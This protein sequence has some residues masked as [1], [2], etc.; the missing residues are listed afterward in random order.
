[1]GRRMGVRH[2]PQLC[3]A[4]YRLV[5]HRFG[6]GRGGAEVSFRAATVKGLA[7]TGTRGGL[8][9][10]AWTSCPDKLLGQATWPS[11]IRRGGWATIA[12][13]ANQKPKKC[14][15]TREQTTQLRPR[16]ARTGAAAL[17]CARGRRDRADAAADAGG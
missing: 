6:R 16:R 2:L 10:A 7:G 13:G 14:E 9:S 17:D 11:L 8:S 3:L 12:F 15:E 4:L 5:R 1:M